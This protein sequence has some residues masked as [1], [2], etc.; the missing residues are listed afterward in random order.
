MAIVITP[1]D[2]RDFCST[3]ATD[4]K[5]QMYIDVA[6][7]K[8]GVCLESTYSEVIAKNLAM[9]AVCLMLSN[10]STGGKISS[11][12]APNGASISYDA[13]DELSGMKE[14]IML[15]DTNNCMID[16]TSN[17]NFAFGTVGTNLNDNGCC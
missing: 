11:E 14:N 16:L 3:D 2:I 17:G 7:D 12:R 10:S 13:S 15:L 8:Y 5:I 4:S 6:L 9:S 1:S